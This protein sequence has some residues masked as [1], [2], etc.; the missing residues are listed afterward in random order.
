[1]APEGI[2]PQG[3]GDAVKAGLAGAGVVRHQVVDLP[4]RD[5]ALSE[6]SA[7]VRGSGPAAFE[8]KFAHWGPCLDQLRARVHC[9]VC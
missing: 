6:H 7:A 5:G 8:L 2:R 3:T 4:L 1:M 9:F